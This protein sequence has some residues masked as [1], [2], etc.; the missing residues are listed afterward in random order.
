[1]WTCHTLCTNKHTGNTKN[2]ILFLTYKYYWSKVGSKS[3]KFDQFWFFFQNFLV[4][5]GWCWNQK[6]NFGTKLRL[7]FGIF[8]KSDFRFGISL[9]FLVLSEFEWVRSDF[10]HWTAYWFLKRFFNFFDF[11]KVIGYFWLRKILV[12][13]ILNL[14]NQ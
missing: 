12:M 1:M 14:L 5:L 13:Y 2:N 11:F 9:K 3:P 8:W 4:F 7:V 6:N 10:V